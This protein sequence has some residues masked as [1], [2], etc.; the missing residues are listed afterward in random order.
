MKS[1]GNQ[2][3]MIVG[4]TAVGKTDLSIEVAKN[5]NGEIISADSVQVYEHLNIGSAKPN[6]EEMQGIPHYLLDCVAPT[7][8]FSVGTYEKKA[9]ALIKEIQGRGKVPIVTGGTGLY[10]NA[11]LFEMDFGG[12]VSNPDVRNDLEEKARSIGN[13]A[14]HQILREKDPVAAD[15][16]HPNNLKR[17]IR[18]LEIIESTGMTIGDFSKDPQITTAYDPVLIGLN[19]SRMKLYARINKRVDMMLNQGLVNEVESL[20]NMGLDDSYQSM[21]GI[22]YKEVLGYLDGRYTYEVMVTML[23]QNSRRYAKRQLTWFKRYPNMNWI[24]LDT[25]KTSEDAL[26][27]ILSYI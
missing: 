4:P 17:V 7:E 24:D 16:I 25:F 18:A 22:G 21:Q 11:L 19:R 8:P 27:S 9:K 6:L 13:E 15:K 20:K 14:L 12:V 26:K 23:K 3:I 10:I 5:L 2:V 1:L